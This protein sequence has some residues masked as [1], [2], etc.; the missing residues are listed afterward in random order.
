MAEGF[1]SFLLINLI[2]FA[3]LEFTTQIL[4]LTP[5]NNVAPE[6]PMNDGNLGNTGDSTYVATSLLEIVSK[7]PCTPHS[8]PSCLN[9]LDSHVCNLPTRIESYE[10]LLIY[11]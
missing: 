4:F 8:C 6:T 9:P 11:A 10:P 3:D 7:S 1:S 2:F 5:L